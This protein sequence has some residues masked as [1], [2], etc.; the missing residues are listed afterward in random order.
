MKRPPPPLN[1]VR[2]FEAAARHLSF[3]R[4]AEELGY[5]QAAISTHVRALEK[6]VGRSLFTRRARSLELTEIGEALLPTL[7]QALAQIDSATDAV[8]TSARDESV[9]VA[10][11]ISLAETWLPGVLARFRATHPAVEVL[12]HGTVWDHGADEIADVVVSVYREDEA[13]PG[14]ERLWRERLVLLCPPP[15]ARGLRA[16]GDALSLPRVEVSGRQEYWHLFAA[17]LGIAEVPR[18]PAA[19]TN[20]SNISLALAAEGLGAVVALRPLG[21]AWTD[22]G[23]LCEPFPEVRPHS[24]WSYHLRA[25]SAR[26]SAA[27]QALLQAIRTA[28]ADM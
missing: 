12:V 22:R 20:S 13:P 19:R 10:C 17:R 26:P 24:P 9:V 1:F 23:L 5:T 6:Y 27:A 3:T 14:C 21:R 8:M 28:A 11:P 4:A 15:M 2:S 7:R 18:G 25:A 16:P